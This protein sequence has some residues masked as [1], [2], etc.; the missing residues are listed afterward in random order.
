[1]ATDCEFCAV[2]SGKAE[3]ES[4]YEDENVMAVLHLKPAHPGQIILFPKE[5]YAILEQIPDYIV[6]HL[7]KIANKLSTA[8][9]ETFNVQGTN[10][11]VQN[12]VAAGQSIPHFCIN[13]I[14]RSEGDGLNFQWEPKK[15][16]KDEV[17]KALIQIK[18]QAGNIHPSGFEKK[19]KKVEPEKE[20]VKK[21]TGKEENYLIKQLKKIP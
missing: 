2:V 16:S 17:E 12:G 10:I 20:E 6:D 1:M 3:S 8:V 15:P 18:E 13:I 19:K 11:V 14:P 5:H 4:I 9:F 21:I 7:F